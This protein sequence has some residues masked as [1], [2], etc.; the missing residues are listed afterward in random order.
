MFDSMSE[1][2]SDGLSELRDAAAE[3][4]DD[5]RAACALAEALYSASKRTEAIEWWEKG[6]RLDRSWPLPWRRLGAAYWNV[7]KD[8]K[9]ARGAYHRAF[10]LDPSDVEV[11]F[12]RDQLWKRLR[13]PPAERL[14]ELENDVQVA[15]RHDELM[16][17]VAG[18]LNLLGEFGRAREVLVARRYAPGDSAA[19][20]VI[21]YARA[22]IGLARQAYWKKEPAWE[23]LAACET[24]PESFGGAACN[25]GVL[26]EVQYWRG[27]MGQEE[28][29][30]RAIDLGHE[31]QETGA[32]WFFAGLAMQELGLNEDARL[33]FVAMEAHA[34]AS[35]DGKI[36]WQPSLK[37]LPT[38]FEDDPAAA[39]IA[40]GQLLLAMA[41]Y[42]LHDRKTARRQLGDILRDDP[43]HGAAGDLMKWLEW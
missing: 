39:R 25:P 8:A 38:P 19:R 29:F 4:P 27:K 3:A 31:P 13:C 11:V 28:A 22:Q 10:K 24:V 16:T 32:G 30:R 40:H 21:Q 36:P 6:V 43:G 37:P 42:S 1:E 23:F 20:A 17:E 9:A 41:N 35:L 18:L 15:F 26:A 12:E 2:L 7:L 5:A 14:Q 33:R 34:V